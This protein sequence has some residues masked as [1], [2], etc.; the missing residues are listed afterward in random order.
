VP[1]VGIVAQVGYGKTTLLA[2]WQHRDDRPFAWVSVDDRDNDPAVLLTYIAAALDR[3]APIDPAILKTLASPGASV[4]S[5]ALPGLGAELLSLP[6]P[7]VIVLDD[8]DLLRDRESLDAICALA[9]HLRDGSQLVLSGRAQGSLPLAGLRAAGRLVELGTTDLRMGSREARVLLR[10]AGLRVSESEAAELV[11]R[12]EGWPAGLYLAALSLQA[13]DREAAG[14]YPFGGR[15]R[16]MA[17]YLRDAHVSALPRKTIQFLRRTSILDRLNASLCDAVLGRGDSGRML[18][19]IEQANLFLVPLD[20]RRESYRYHVLFRELLQ[21]ELDRC[22]PHLVAELNGRAADWC[23]AN[24]EH[25]AAVEY[26]VRAGDLDRVARLVAV[27]A[28]PLHYAGRIATVERW[29]G[30]FDDDRLIARYPAVAVL[31]A[32]VHAVRG[33]AA[34]ADRWGDLAGERAGREKLPAGS[35]TAEPWLAVLRAARCRDGFEGMRADAELALETLAPGSL[36]RPTAVLLVAMSHLLAGDAVTADAVLAGVVEAASAADAPAPAR[37]A[38]AERALVALDEGRLHEADGFLERADGLVDAGALADYGSSTLVLAARA[39]SALRRGD[40]VSARDHLASAQ[41]LRP[42]LGRAF[43]WLTTQALLELARAALSLVD[44]SGARA[45]LADADEVLRLGPDLGV[46]TGRA[47]ELRAQLSSSDEP[48]ARWACTLTAAELRLLPLLT[49]HL[50]FREI[51]ARL[52]VSRN[53]VKAQAISLYRKLHVT[54][55]SEAIERAA[56]LGLVDSPVVR[57]T[58]DFIPAG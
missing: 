7:V 28:L 18:D 19:S 45:L 46:L 55:R 24:A 4:W 56:E 22:E 17:D 44:L 8:A 9:R 16:Y 57:T 43:P 23:E 30:A 3:V 50:S 48:Q 41:R 37:L 20:R 10:S 58:Q 25:E 34:L 35:T 14:P 27:H 53:T 38:L 6:S 54:S 51:A 1:V 47:R 26:A 49:T 13:A 31:G 15:D 40:P 36:W 2:Q 32:W 11:R 29:L 21:G 33:R 52:Y 12:T 39:R 42:Q 5:K